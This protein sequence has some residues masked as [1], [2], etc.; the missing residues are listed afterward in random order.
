MNLGSET[1]LVEF[2]K[3]TGEHREAMEAISAILNKHGHGD[4]YFGV[5][6]DGEVVGQNVSDKTLRQVGQWIA[7]KI[8]PA[9]HPFIEK[10]S[11]ESGH[12]Y[13]HV[14]FAGGEPPYSAD[15]RYFMRVGTG[16]DQLSSSTLKRFAAENYGNFSAWDKRSS[17]KTVADVDEKTLRKYYERGAE[18]GRMPFEYTDAKACLSALHLLCD[19]GTLTNAGAV[20]FVPAHEVMLRM[21]VFADSERVDILDNQQAS[22][23][24]FSMVDAAELYILNNTRRAFVIDG[25]SLHRKEVPE[26]PMAAVREALLNAF[27]HRDYQNSACVQVDIFWDSVNVFSPGRFSE[28]ITPDDYLTGNIHESRGR[29]K[30]LAETLYK[31]KDIE[32][33]ATGL[34]RSWSPLRGDAVENGRKHSLRSSRGYSCSQLGKQHR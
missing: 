9:I 17:G 18:S 4:L 11:D 16:K 22:G 10:L 34:R 1:E 26:I 32:S 24:L 27:C 20:C 14:K 31:S 19:D 30:L 15:G 23:T 29:N 7:D 12:D 21:G 33:F 8:E 5:R 2:K 25:S 3:S 28:G 6:D 13:I